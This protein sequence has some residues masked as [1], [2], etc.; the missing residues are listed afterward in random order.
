MAIHWGSLVLNSTQEIKI[1]LWIKEYPLK[2]FPQ[3]S[4]SHLNTFSMMNGKGKYS[5]VSKNQEPLEAGR[6]WSE[7]Q[8]WGLHNPNPSNNTT[9]SW[10]PNRAFC[11]N[12]KEL[13]NRL[14]TTRLWLD[15]SH[16][17]WCLNLL[18]KLSSWPSFK[19]NTS[20]MSGFKAKFSFSLP[21][22]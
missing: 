17:E 22:I 16:G 1:S 20:P 10:V 4:Q 8:L 7:T 3:C 9:I 11:S 12:H 18:H 5:K 21:G 15:G 13:D 2:H 19:G 14:W 6:I